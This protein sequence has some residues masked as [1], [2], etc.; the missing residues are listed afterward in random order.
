MTMFMNA[1]GTAE[2]RIIREKAH[3]RREKFEQI[4][5][6]R[7]Q[8]SDLTGIPLEKISCI[9]QADGEYTLHSEEYP[10]ISIRLGG[11]QQ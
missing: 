9:V 11:D 10:S 2:L 6:V 3:R 5:R 8:L 7:Q 4:M 1:W